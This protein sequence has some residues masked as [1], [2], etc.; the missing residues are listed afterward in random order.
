MKFLRGR[1]LRPGSGLTY[2]MAD[3]PYAIHCSDQVEYVPLSPVLW[4]A[5]WYDV[6]CGRVISRHRTRR[7][8]EQAI[9][10]HS[11]AAKKA[12]TRK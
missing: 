7:G 10:R 8:A 9:L 2:R 5:I 4:L 1:R 11:K 6:P 12:T 3:E